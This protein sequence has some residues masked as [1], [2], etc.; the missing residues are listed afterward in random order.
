MLFRSF[1]SHDRWYSERSVLGYNIFGAILEESNFFTENQQQR[2]SRVRHGL[3]D[4][5]ESVYNS[6]KRRMESRFLR[7]GKL[8]GMLV[9]LSSKKA[10]NSFTERRINE[11][12]ND[13]KVFVREHAIYEVRDSKSYSGKKFRVAI[14]TDNLMSRILEEAEPNPEGMRIIEVPV[15]FKTAFEKNLD[16]S[17]RDIA[18]YATPSVTPFLP[19]RDRI[20]ACIDGTKRHPFSKY[21]WVQDEKADFLWSEMVT[22]EKDGAYRPKINPSAPRHVHFDLSKNNDATGVCMMHI[23]GYKSIERVGG[24]VETVPIFVVDFL[25]RVEAP[26]NGEIVQ[27]ELRRMVYDLSAHGYFIKEITADSFQ[28]LS[29]IQTFKQKG[30]KSRTVSVDAVGPYNLLKQ[31]IY[32]ER[33]S[34]YRYDPLL[35]ELRELEK[36]EKTG[37]VDHPT[38]GSKDVSD[39]LCGA[40]ATLCETA[41]GFQS[42]FQS[43][44][45]TVEEE[46][47]DSWLLG[48]R[49]VPVQS[50]VD[51]D[52]PEWR[53]EARR[54][55]AE[56]ASPAGQAQDEWRKKFEMPFEVG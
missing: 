14:G 51:S 47:N 49:A 42:T 6:I 23:G 55:E 41:S 43:S 32:E 12:R 4:N 39:A 2:A 16:E 29:M 8:P 26:V 17:I 53:K 7:N 24:I 25:L 50:E 11:A 33:V 18:G 56:K 37:K 45:D 48:S 40:F 30:Y 46:E 21:V 22:M 15:E 44:V 31:A 10:L 19:R 5:A 54:I 9:M 3:T 20:N 13:P 34:Y 27:S 36:N 38:M 52:E 35:K 28:S 1:P